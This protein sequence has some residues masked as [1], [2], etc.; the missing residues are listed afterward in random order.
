MVPGET[1]VQHLDRQR[2]G[3]NGAMEMVAKKLVDRIS[4]PIQP[5]QQ[6]PDRCPL[7]DDFV[8]GLVDARQDTGKTGMDQRRK[9]L[10]ERAHDF[11]PNHPMSAENN[12]MATAASQSACMKQ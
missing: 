11:L 6:R 9:S 8:N 5:L 1:E 4:G 10:P 12:S 3:G 2:S 7:A